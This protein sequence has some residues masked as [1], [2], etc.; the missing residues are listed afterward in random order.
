MNP[1]ILRNIICLFFLLNSFSLYAQ[2]IPAGLYK[3]LEIITVTPDKTAYWPGVYNFGPRAYDVKGKPDSLEEKWFHE[4]SIMVTDSILTIHKKP[5]TIKNGIKTYS[6]STGGF[7]SYK[8]RLYNVNDTT[9]NVHGALINCT[10]CPRGATG[11]PRYINVFYVFH[12]ANNHW[13][14][15]TPFE[16]GLV[17]SRE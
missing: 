5:V 17:F 7:Y 15:D 3:G 1:S 16:K 11:T 8:G 12:P 10:F 14:V 2:K 9:I 6:D 4:V 13:R